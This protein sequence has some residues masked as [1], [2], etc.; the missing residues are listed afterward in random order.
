MSDYLKFRGKCKE[1][2][3]ALAAKHPN[4]TLVRGFYYE[5]LWSREEQH[6]WCVDEQGT[7]HDPSRKQFP[8]GGIPEFYKAFDG[9]I[10]CAECGNQVAEDQARLDGR[11]AF[12]SYECNGKFVG[13]L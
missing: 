9:M 5:P 3:E 6:W 8:S 12:C 2:S 13:V 7:I 11:Y 1:L 10:D 4:Y